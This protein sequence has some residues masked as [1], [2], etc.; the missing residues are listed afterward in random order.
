V[1]DISHNKGSWGASIAGLRIVNNIM[2]VS[3]GKIYG[4]ETH[5]LPSSVVLDHNLF[6]NA[7]TGYLFTVVGMGGTHSIDVF[8]SWTGRES[9][10]RVGDPKFVSSANR[11]YRVQSGSPAIDAG[12]LLPGVTDGYQGA[13]PDIGRY[14]H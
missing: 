3:T 9:H 10:G 8:R 1:F 2:S 7:G 11:D 12:R 6:H 5:P 14:E 4:I 13:A